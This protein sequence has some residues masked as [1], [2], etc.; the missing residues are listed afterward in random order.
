MC[1]ARTITATTEKRPLGQWWNALARLIPELRCAYLL[2]LPPDQPGRELG[3][4]FPAR[5]EQTEE[6]KLA[7]RLAYRTGAPVTGSIPGPSGCEA[8]LRIAYPLSDEGIAR[9]A[10]VVEAALPMAR[11]GEIL[12]AL[13]WAEA[14]L[15]M[16]IREPARVDEPGGLGN[17]IDAGLAQADYADVLV[18]I[19]A[20][21][22]DAVGST[23]VSLGRRQGETVV[24]E[25][26]SGVS[27]LNR[28][29][30]RVKVMQRI[31][32]DALDAHGSFVWPK[33][34]DAVEL[35]PLRQLV[36][37]SSSLGGAC[38]VSLSEGMPQ[39]LVFLF[40]FTADAG[41]DQAV[42]RRCN[43]AARVVAP[44]I[45]WR[46]EQS[47]PWWRRLL[48]LCEAGLG[49][50]FGSA[51]RARRLLAALAIGL[52]AVLAMTPTDYR[53]TAPAV[54]EGAVQRSVV[55]PYDGFIGTAEARAGQRV[56]KGDLLL[57]L[58][59]RE[60][61][62]RL[63]HLHAES[64]ELSNQRRQA[65]AT[66]DHGEASILA[67]RL[68][69]VAARLQ[70]IEHQ[71]QRIELRAPFDG[72]VITGDWS[73]SQGMPVTR[74]D[75]LFEVAPLDQFRIALEVGDSTISE[76]AIGQSGEV[77]LSAMPGEPIAVR[78]TA[79]AAVSG[80]DNTKPV[81]RVE[82]EPVGQAPALRPGMQGLAKVSVGERSRW[83]VW[84]HALTDWISLQL[85]RLLP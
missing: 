52:F 62:E 21:L 34:G 73:R 64:S 81:F 33:S 7:A 24:I 27:D 31:M 80:E 25:A 11:Q 61:L 1:S 13:K 77:I 37:R 44:L 78:L 10:V 36:E 82:A 19:L 69:Q 15:G 40:E 53:V 14:S 54:I 35:P 47:R 29:N 5:E 28:R 43:E 32:Q 49:E 75:V 30:Q 74:G 42:D 3:H 9:G 48:A 85:W 6:L 67:A 23:R 83:W 63:R 84:T 57:R 70:L 71:L 38:V 59:D 79:I 72:S 60:L 39:P 50:V 8:C 17:V 65:L 76:V 66:L 41:W 16:V 18:V 56:R 55:V 12:T 2:L 45:Q 4:M 46:S 51:G 58:D 26:V 22:C 68:E 20:R